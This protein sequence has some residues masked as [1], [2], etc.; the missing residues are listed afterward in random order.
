MNQRG[1]LMTG[2]C[3]AFKCIHK[4]LVFL[5][6]V[7]VLLISLIAEMMMYQLTVVSE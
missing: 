4:E 2:L 5:M 6:Y 7:C 1:D 3:K